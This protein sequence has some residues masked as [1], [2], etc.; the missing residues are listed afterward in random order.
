MGERGRARV[1]E[2]FTW[3]TIARQFMEQLSAAEQQGPLC[4]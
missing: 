3:Q 4:A 2:R 1:T